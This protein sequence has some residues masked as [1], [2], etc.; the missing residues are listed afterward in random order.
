MGV[1]TDTVFGWSVAA[2]RLRTYLDK[3]NTPLRGWLGPSKSL[4]P[5]PRSGCLQPGGLW[6]PKLLADA[7]CDV[8]LGGEVLTCLQR[9][10]AVP[11][12]S[13]ARP[14]ERTSP[15]KHY[16]TLAVDDIGL[17]CPKEIVLIDDVVTRGSTFLG[18]ASRLHD[19]CPD[20]TVTAFAVIRTMGYFLPFKKALDPCVGTICMDSFGNLRRDP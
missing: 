20:A 7:L 4:V 6:V 12:S 3:N 18:A 9:T 8:G 17:H 11:R 2:Q 5:V 14:G 15:Q 1:S 16:Q 19:A 13:V 10:V